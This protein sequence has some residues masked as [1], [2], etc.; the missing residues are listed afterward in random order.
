MDDRYSLWHLPIFLPN[1]CTQVFHLKKP[2]FYSVLKGKIYLPYSTSDACTVHDTFISAQILVEFSCTW[3]WFHSWRVAH[4]YPSFTTT[5]TTNYKTND[6][7]RSVY[8]CRLFFPVQS[9]PTHHKHLRCG[10]FLFVYRD[11]QSCLYWRGVLKRWYCLMSS[12]VDQNFQIF[13]KSFT[14]IL[15]G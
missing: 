2:W 9:C 3:G 12:N 5:I 7:T 6:K 13:L 11:C 1:K 15:A 8:I 10:Q 4:W 14:H